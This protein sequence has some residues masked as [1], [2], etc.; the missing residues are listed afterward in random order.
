MQNR[1]ERLQVPSADSPVLGQAELVIDQGTDSGKRFLLEQNSTLG[2]NEQCKIKLSDPFVSGKHCSLH[3]KE[4]RLLLK[5]LQSTNGT[6]LGTKKIKEVTVHLFES[7]RVGQTTF[8][9]T[10]F[11]L[12]QATE[13]CDTLSS[14]NKQMKELFRQIKSVAD[15][16]ETVLIE[17]ETGTGKELV[18]R[19][20]HNLSPRKNE[21]LIA[22]NCGALAAEV[23][24][25]ELFGH[26]RGAFTGA[27]RLREGAFV[28]A[29]KGTI[30]LD[31]IGELPL[32]LQ[33][34]LLRVLEN[35]EVKPVGADRT[36]N[37]TARVIA[38]TNR[39]L[40]QEVENGNFREDLFFRINLIPLK[41]PPLRERKEDLPNLINFFLKD[42]GGA[43]SPEAKKILLDY[44][45]PGNVRELKHL[46]TRSHY[47]SKH[48][49]IELDD[50]FLPPPTDALKEEI[51]QN[52]GDIPP[53]D[54]IEK[55]AIASV[56]KQ[57]KGNKTQAAKRLKISKSTLLNRIRRYGI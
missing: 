2:T 33:P 16:K 10:P 8:S 31:E 26:T 24:E 34:K 13:T 17:G 40:K 37:V 41:I 45:W 28:A 29:K 5:D 52:M 30:F 43:M 46:I 44:H 25:S 7:I 51:F 47:L 14:S 3:F 21:P 49:R 50:L 23:I 1:T 53:L 12:E 11:Q 42:I 4:D 9:I 56:L 27:E 6:F 18:A 20:I 54:E 55:Y 32:Q 19:A 57:T 22:I 15:A 38:A 48:R 35:R 36:T 39:N